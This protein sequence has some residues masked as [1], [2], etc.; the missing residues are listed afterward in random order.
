[1]LD[2]ARRVAAKTRG[3]TIDQFRADENL[4]LAVVH[5][6]QVIGEAATRVSADVRRNNTGLPREPVIG[7]RHRLVHDYGNINYDIVWSVATEEMPMLIEAL[8]RLVP[9]AP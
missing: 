1:M 5:L 7:M 9:R 4:Q 2:A 3:L 8:E 6:V